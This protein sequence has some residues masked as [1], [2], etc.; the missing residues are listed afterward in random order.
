MRA[1]IVLVA[2]LAT[3]CM[4]DW[5]PE[6]RVIPTAPGEASLRMP[7]RW[8]QGEPVDIELHWPNAIVNACGPEDW[9]C[10]EPHPT[11]TVMSV[12]CRG[13]TVTLDPSG[14]TTTWITD[15][16]AVTAT[17]DPLWFDATLR[18]D[19][20]GTLA[21]LT[22]T[23]LGDHEVGLEIGCMVID[24]RALTEH[25]P[26]EDAR[27]CG[28]TRRAN[29][30]ILL[31]PGIRTFRGALRFPYCSADN[32]RCRGMLGE[33]Y[34]PASEISIVP[35]PAYWLYANL[36]V[37]GRHAVLPASVTATT[38]TVTATLATGTVVTT[39]IALPVV[40][41]AGGAA[42]LSE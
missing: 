26:G 18:F 36:F 41:T 25:V 24:S 34:R 20:T 39:T 17:D 11:M 9:F 19:A 16:T 3:A 33:H 22:G 12:G 31:G 1:A 32:P 27:W 10:H 38:A 21:S 30:A 14:T 42:D 29:D 40:A 4:S 23:A 28:A 13:C 15:A 6:T 2:V 8:I 35:T 37:T 5:S 7:E